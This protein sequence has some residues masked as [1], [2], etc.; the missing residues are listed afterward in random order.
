MGA[1]AVAPCSKAVER[2]AFKGG[3]LGLKPAGARL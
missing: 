2:L 1:Q 3:N